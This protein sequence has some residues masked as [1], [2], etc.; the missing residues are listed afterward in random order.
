MV[1]QK[2]NVSLSVQA[3]SLAT[4]L[5]RDCDVMA[6]QDMAGSLCTKLDHLLLAHLESLAQ[7][8]RQDQ[9]S[10]GQLRPLST[11]HMT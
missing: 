2:G 9:Q 6:A 1:V 8:R 4:V 10:Q 7:L 5:Q 11:L 3:E